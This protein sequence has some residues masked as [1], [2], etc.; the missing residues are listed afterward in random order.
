ME[1]KIKKI[2]FLDYDSVIDFLMD[3]DSM[4]PIILSGYRHLSNTNLET[5]DIIELSW[6]SSDIINVSINKNDSEETLDKLIGWLEKWER[7]EECIEISN[8]KK[9]HKG[10]M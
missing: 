2:N 7:Y 4:F 1:W 8:L 5:L 3:E 6:G 10:T 9:L